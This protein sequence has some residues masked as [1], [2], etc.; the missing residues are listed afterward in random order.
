MQTYF[1]T[2]FPA[3]RGAAPTPPGSSTHLGFL[4]WGPSPHGG[5]RMFYFAIASF[6]SYVFLPTGFIHFG[7]DKYY[8]KNLIKLV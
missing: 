3:R 2:V 7:C 6:Y 4:D 8:G 1:S 5:A